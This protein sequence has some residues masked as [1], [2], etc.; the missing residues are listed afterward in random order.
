M[1][2]KGSNT[3]KRTKEEEVEMEKGDCGP[4]T[5]KAASWFNPDKILKR[6]WLPCLKGR[7]SSRSFS[8]SHLL[9]KL[10]QVGSL[11]NFVQGVKVSAKN[12]TKKKMTTQFS[13]KPKEDVSIWVWF[14]F[15]SFYPRKL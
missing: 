4:P 8:W 5:Q 12:K 15:Q 6:Q 13:S 1:I 10:A 3:E 7:K 14:Q 9:S 2:K 11:H